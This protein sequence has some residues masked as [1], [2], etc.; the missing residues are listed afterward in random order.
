M[1]IS[2][3]CMSIFLT[4][5]SLLLYCWESAFSFMDRLVVK[6]HNWAIRSRFLSMEGCIRHPSQLKGEKY[7][8]IGKKTYIG[9]G[10]II[11]AWD[12]YMNEH[13]T[14]SI[15]IGENCSIGEFAHITA[16]TKIVIGNN[17]LTGRYLFIADNYH[18][19]SSMEQMSLPPIERPLY[20]KGTVTI[21]NNVWIGERVCVLSGVTIGDGAIIASNAVVTH[22][23]EAG[24]IV[25]GIP[26]KVIKN[27]NPL[28]KEEKS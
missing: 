4:I 8:S 6:L 12:S 21:G 23:V 13:F 5:L 9:K 1:L 28:V 14:P 20:T 7:I 27:V 26:A 3:E 25:G 2:K 18:G 10:C 15:E 17:V 16:C 22:D 24:T 19:N 11:T